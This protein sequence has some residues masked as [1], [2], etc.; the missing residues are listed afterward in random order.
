[1]K[2]IPKGLSN[3][4]AVTFVETSDTNGSDSRYIVHIKDGYYFTQGHAAG[5]SGS[6]GVDTVADFL[7]A[8]PEKKQEN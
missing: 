5:C 7:Y 3:H 4:P 6:I 1:M 8:K 2:K